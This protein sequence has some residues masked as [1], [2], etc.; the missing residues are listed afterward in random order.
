MAKRDAVRVARVVALLAT[1]LLAGC[2]QPRAAAGNDGVIVV[3]SSDGASGNAAALQADELGKPG[4]LG[5]VCVDDAIRPIEGARVDLPGY[6]RNETS[7][8]DGG[9]GFVDLP[10]GSYFVRVDRAGYIGAETVVD[11]HPGEFTRTK[12]VLTSIPPPQPY[13]ETQTFNGFSEV[14]GPADLVQGSLVC[15][16]CQFPFASDSAGRTAIVI[17]A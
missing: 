13:H 5:G 7:D 3:A 8:R 2:S 10:P 6:D 16:H 1:A 9:F 14:T 11:V 15:Q 17:A 4:H 12:F